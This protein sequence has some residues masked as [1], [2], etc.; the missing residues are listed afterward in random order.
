MRKALFFLLLLPLLLLLFPAC[1]SSTR[2][3]TVAPAAVNI[4]K[5]YKKVLLINR[6]KEDPKFSQSNKME[7]MLTGTWAK[8][9]PQLSF[10]VL[11]GLSAELTSSMKAYEVKTL[12]DT[13]FMG[14]GNQQYPETFTPVFIDSL[15]KKYGVD[16]VI[17]LETFHFDIVS[18]AN[19]KPATFNV[20]GIG[21][22]NVMSGPTYSLAAL[23]K[24]GFRIYPSSGTGLIDQFTNT[25]TWDFQ[26]DGVADL[27]VLTQLSTAKE[28]VNRALR[29]CGSDYG[30]T[31]SPHP[32]SIY[33][34]VYT[35]G[36]ET[37]E[38]A[39]R[40]TNLGQWDPAMNIWDK[41]LTST[42]SKL[43]KR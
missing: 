38:A 29:F 31:L 2:I 13:L 7:R 30:Y 14:T 35:R 20:V 15:C 34:T 39:G 9:N 19:G 28:S 24:G 3:D 22:A 23:V 17:A 36:H 41:N 10:Q 40:Y 11:S 43:K 18:K 1:T 16:F 5:E 37:L 33:R 26:R 42:N 12:T 25:I 4:P 8:N 32:I 6:T 21:L 27:P